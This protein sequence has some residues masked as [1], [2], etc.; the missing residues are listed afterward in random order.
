M[1]LWSNSFEGPASLD[2]DASD[3]GGPRSMSHWVELSFTITGVWVTSQL[4]PHCF[5]RSWAALSRLRRRV[6][7]SLFEFKTELD[8]LSQFRRRHLVSLICYCNQKNEM[9]IIYQYMENETLKDHLY[10]SDVPNLDWTQRHEICIGSAKGLHYF[11]A[12]SHKAI[13]HHDVK[14]SN[15]LLDE[16]LRAKKIPE[17]LVKYVAEKCLA[18]YGANRPTEL[19]ISIESSRRKPTQDDKILDNQLDN[20]MLSIK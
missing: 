10:G 4:G 11:H 7:D 2:V 16:N 19:G 9:I 6:P 12:G 5:S 14:S 15:I 8:M 20:S 13:I 18:K 17:S 3:R 1:K